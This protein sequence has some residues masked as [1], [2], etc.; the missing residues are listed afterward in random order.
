[1]IDETGPTAGSIITA[2]GITQ[3]FALGLPYTCR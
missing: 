3:I 2:L 1:M